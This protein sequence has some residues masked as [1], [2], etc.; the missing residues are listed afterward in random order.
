MWTAQDTRCGQ[1]RMQDVDSAGHKMWTAQDTRCGQRRI[2][3]VDSAGHKMWTNTY[4]VAQTISY[5]VQLA[6]NRS[7]VHLFGPDRD[8]ENNEQ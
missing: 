7:F 8:T 2:Q 4:W 1:R 5:Q 3:D 6:V